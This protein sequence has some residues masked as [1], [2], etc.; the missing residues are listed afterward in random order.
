MSNEHSHKWLALVL[1]CAVQFMVVLDVAIVNV[2]LPTIQKAL[3][4]SD[5]NLQ[6]VVSAYTLTFGG[7]LMLGSRIADLLGRKRM[8]IA[9]L[10]L[11][12]GA[13]LACGLSGSDTQL[14]AFRA[15]QGLGAAIISPAALSILTTTF[16]EGEER[17]KALGIWGAIAGMGGAVGVLL[18]GILTDQVGW[19]WIFFLNVP[20]G[21]VVILAGQ[22]VLMESRVEM[23]TRSLDI[24]GAILVTAGLTLLVYGLVSTDTHSW[25]S[26]LVLG[27]LIGSA[28]LL[29]AFV[30]AEMRAA[31]PILPFSI[32]RNRSLTGA[33]IVGL[34]LGASIF[35]MFFL[36]S[37][38]MQQVLGYSALKA[39]LA[40][41]LVASVIIVAAGASQ[42]LVTRIGVRTVLTAGMVLLIAGLL[43]FSRVAVDGSYTVDLVPGFILAGLGLGFSFVPVQ[44]ASLVGVS[45]DEAG[46]AS[47][48]INTSQ[49]VGGALGVAILS[50]ITF[51]RVDSYLTDHHG[52]QALFPNAL[53]DGFHVAFLAGAG[54]ALIGLVATVLFIPKAAMAP[55]IVPEPVT[56]AA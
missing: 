25:T 34:L 56:E 30:V 51:T 17:N 52:N 6:W 23:E 19:E 18:G 35:S 29:A 8:F 32:F 38:Y 41:L 49:Q 3:N 33:N 31:A 5:A 2:A 1:L 27:S 12:S 37:L 36:L 20:I 21:I 43:W 45:N 44:I 39:G 40:Y 22:R 47:G 4:F 53:V 11:F 13:S 46:I 24:L 16:E 26:T 42:A 10:V 50:T 15:I 54:L 7:F 48:L 14:I 9:G 55:E 28:V